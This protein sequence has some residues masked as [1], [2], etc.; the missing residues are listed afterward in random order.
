MQSKKRTMIGYLFLIPTITVFVFLIA[1]PV[2]STIRMS[3][4]SYR[5]QTIKEGMKWIGL[6]NYLSMLDDPKVLET[7][8][9]TLKF[10]V[11]SVFLETVIGMICA[12]V[13][14]RHFKGQAFV[15]MMILIPWCIPTIVSGLMWSYMYAESFGIINFLLLKLG[16]VREPIR[17][18]TDTKYAFTAVIIA[19]IW[20]TVPYMSLL[21]LSGLKTVSKDYIEAAAI[22]GAGGV[23]TLFQIVLPNM[24]SVVMVSV[25]FRTIASFRIYDLIKVLTNGGPQGST[26][27][28]TMYGYGAVFYKWKYGLWCC[29]G[30]LNICRIDSY[31][32]VLLRCT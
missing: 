21:L 32:T 6:K 28:L 18:I 16:I 26:K 30:N 27:S 8:L 19:D 1:Y 20:K 29:S 2:Y 14:N 12:L 5:A 22:D 7:L 24:K 31:C 4:F 11:V 15:R 9:F 23:R 13:M 3:F 17:W 10:T 25:M